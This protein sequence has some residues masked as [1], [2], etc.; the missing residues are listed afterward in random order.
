MKNHGVKPVLLSR[1]QIEALQRI[2][3]E[4][5]QKSVLGVAP[6]IHVIA[7]QLMDKALKEVRL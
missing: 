1:G 4:K 6:S 7:R 2:Q 3:A 5:R